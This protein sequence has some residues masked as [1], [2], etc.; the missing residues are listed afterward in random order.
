MLFMKYSHVLDRPSLL[1]EA[2]GFTTRLRRDKKGNQDEK[3]IHSRIGGNGSVR[4]LG[5]R[6]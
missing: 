1:V 5:N 3:E 2:H 4:G 6:L